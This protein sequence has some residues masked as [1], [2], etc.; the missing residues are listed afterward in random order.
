MLLTATL[1]FCNAR[2]LFGPVFVNFIELLYTFGSGTFE[3]HVICCGCSMKRAYWLLIVPL[4]YGLTA[5]TGETSALPTV[6]ST[7]PTPAAEFEEIAAVTSLSEQTAATAGADDSNAAWIPQI[8][9]FDGVEMVLVPPGCFTMGDDAGE[10][11]EVPAHTQCFDEPFY[12]DRFEVTNEQFE[13]FDGAAAEAS[14][15]IDPNRPRERVTW[16]EARDFCEARGDKV[17]LPTEAEWE[18]AARGP[19][20]LVFPWGNSIDT[21]HVAYSLSSSSQTAEVGSYP[22]G[23]SWVGAQ[24]MSGNV[25]EW[26]STIYS[27]YISYPY[28]SSDGRESADDTES[29]RAQRGGSFLDDVQHIR[30]AN[31][32]GAY[33]QYWGSDYGFRCARSR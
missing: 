28:D 2:F 12:I 9:V 7:Q 14:H 23:A 22:D 16:F 31:R 3:Q 24:D 19:D 26:V 17:R 8:E 1:Q 21:G 10:E 6:S 18:Y 20:S 25:R 15:W 5:C 29:R 13:R 33:P 27:F 4:A 30:A 11:D 32:D